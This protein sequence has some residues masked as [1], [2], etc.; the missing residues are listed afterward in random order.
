MG[1]RQ[2]AKKT[3]SAP[4]RVKSEDAFEEAVEDK[5]KNKNMSYEKDDF[6]KDKV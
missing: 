5:V 6:L 2:N 1:N 3:D 4:K